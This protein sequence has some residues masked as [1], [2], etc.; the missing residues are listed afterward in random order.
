MND[1]TFDKPI[2][3]ETAKAFEWFCR[4]RDLGGERTLAKVSELYEKGKAYIQQLQKWSRQHR[5]VPR[6][7]SF[8]QHRNQILLK[9]QAVIERERTRLS[10]QQWNE[11]RT[12]LREEQWKMS[13]LLLTKGREMLEYS[14]DERRWTFRDAS[15]MVQLGIELGRSAAEIDDLDIFTAIKTLAQSNILPKEVC[16]RLKATFD[17]LVS[18]VRTSVVEGC[19]DYHEK[20]DDL[21]L[22]ENEDDL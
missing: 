21:L 20:E 8:D 15:A 18:E 9:E 1:E 10:A 3:G 13:Q 11:R 16:D 22:A 2:P 7:L 5:W 17:D 14:L 4:Y 19:L 6:A 12:Q